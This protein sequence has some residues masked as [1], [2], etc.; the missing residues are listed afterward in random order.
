[1]IG[2]D[3]IEIMSSKDQWEA[4]TP[5]DSDIVELYGLAMKAMRE[6]NFDPKALMSINDKFD[7][8]AR[9]FVNKLSFGYDQVGRKVTFEQLFGEIKAVRPEY[10][11]YLCA[12]MLMLWSIERKLRIIREEELGITK[13]YEAVN[14][15]SS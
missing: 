2:L 7:A 14:I 1:M 9:S 3:G 15:M 12:K 8:A 13:K 5:F 6:G 11:P 10:L 4:F